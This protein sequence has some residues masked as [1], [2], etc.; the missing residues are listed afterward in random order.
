MR[1]ASIKALF[2]G[3][4]FTSAFLLF[5]VQPL[6]A[7][8]IL[9][10]FGG[11]AAV[12][13]ICMVFFQVVL[14]A[15]YAYSDWITRR[16]AARA[17]AR[18][19]VGLLLAS[20][21][22]L[23][24]VTNARW[25]PT[26][27]EDPTLW[28]LGLL[29]GTIGLP[30][31]L[32]S[33]TGPL[34][35]SWVARTPWGAQVYRYF[36]LS[37]FASLASLLS[38]PVL[39]EPRSTLVQQAWGWSIAYGVFV[40]LCAGTTLYVAR[41]WA[42]G[43]H[44]ATRKP[45]V[46]EMPAAKPRI[47][48]Y[49][50]WLALPALGSWLLLAITNHITQNVA[51]IPFLW[52]LPLSVYLLSFVLTFE[53]DRWYRR[54]V[55][56]PLAAVMLALCAFGLQDSLGSN[57]RTAL[58]IYVVG[59]FALCMFLHGEM[60]RLR[61]GSAYLTRFYLMLSLGGAL[62]GVS[63]GLVAPHV[64]PAY[65]ELGVG[66]TLCALIAAVLWRQRRVGMAASLA[67]AGACAW[68][69][70]LQVEGD[71]TG[72][73]RMQ[74]NFYG[75]LVTLDTLR[76]EAKDH[77]RQ[78]YHGSVKHGEQYLA[79]ARRREPTTYYGPSSGV[80]LAIAAAPARSR[81]IGLI[82]LG[83]G[84][85]ATYGRP[86]D[87]Y[88]VYEINPEVFDLADSEFSFLADSPARIERVL[89]DARLAL[90][91]EPPQAFDVLA[92]DAFSGDSVPIHLITSEAMDVYLRHMRPEGIVA[93]HVTNRFL[94]LAPVVEKIALAKGLHVALVHDEPS[95]EGLR[96]TDWV[97]VA[98]EPGRLANGAIRLASSKIEQIAGLEPW[99][100]DYNNLFGVL[101]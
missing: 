100:D 11:S 80:G 27:A 16:L 61:P 13:S 82:G 29:L 76:G 35:Q 60:S 72:A 88:R 42:A 70:A 34:V 31:F 30:Y 98:R 94:A 45:G 91:R 63:V 67:L 41:H 19:H 53:S 79:P 66:L 51:A 55:F 89:G 17:Q 44:P 32:L 52:V 36:S 6:I 23:P 87:V 71:A 59:L 25:K 2:A 58:P 48:D 101:K 93:F 65:Y 21:A 38:Y 47:A 22:F 56:V 73:R 81:R 74:R 37:N 49:L 96:N 78:M 57:L 3:T 5:L 24:I 50:T 83:A 84:T 97:L 15:G 75:T 12:W 4:I 54:A 18:L 10:W 43:A 99:T 8:Q 33:T 39:I 9:P 92:V 68:F 62:G 14:L 1:P 28:I 86:G 26:G 77:V 85:L 64:L 46:E 90:E 7:K 40:V 69:L 20:L 95:A